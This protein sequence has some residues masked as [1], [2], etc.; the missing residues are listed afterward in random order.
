MLGGCGGGIGAGPFTRDAERARACS[1]AA[2]V[3][4]RVPLPGAL[5]LLVG[6]TACRLGWSLHAAGNGIC[7]DILKALEALLK[8]P[9]AERAAR[10]GMG[11]AGVREAKALVVAT[12]AEVKEAARAVVVRAVGSEVE[13]MVAG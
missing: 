3:R 13:A 4:R 5:L 11:M 1:W 10:K 8:K 6:V 2:R 9:Q 12:A 7:D